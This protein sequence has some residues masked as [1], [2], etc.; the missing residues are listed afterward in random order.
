[1]PEA[2]T[3]DKKKL[4]LLVGLR[5]VLIL[6]CVI[7]VLLQAGEWHISSLSQY[8]TAWIFLQWML[9]INSLY[10][11]FIPFG[12]NFFRGFIAFQLLVDFLAETILIYLT[13][14]VFSVF[15]SLYFVSIILAGVLI[16]PNNSL[17]CASVATIGISGNAFVYFLA[18][19]QDMELPFL[20]RENIY[21]FLVAID[22][23]F[24]K[25]YL[26]A[27]GVSFYLVAFLSSRL[28]TTISRERILQK[29]ILQNLQDGV[30]V[31]DDREHTIFLNDSCRNILGLEVYDGW[32]GELI[33]RLLDIDRHRE[34]LK[35]IKLKCPCIFDTQV[36][37]ERKLVPVQVTVSNI[38]R[39]GKVRAIIL[40]LRDMTY[41][42]RMEEAIQRAN[43]FSAISEIAAM[44]AHEIR[45]P[46]TSIRGAVQ[47]LQN[48]VPPEDPRYVLMN[49]TIRESDRINGI[50]T[51]FLEFS[52]IRRPVFQ[53]CNVTELLQETLLLLGKREEAANAR[54]DREIE[55]NLIIKADAEQLKQIFYNLG[56]NAIESSS[57]SVALRVTAQRKNRARFAP[58]SLEECPGVEISFHDQGKG[59]SDE[60][61]QR[62]FTPFFTTKSQGTGMGL[63]FVNKMLEFHRGRYHIESAV[64]K[65]TS[66]YLWFPED[67]EE[68]FKA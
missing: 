20:P 34:I 68:T 36:P 40:I 42:K 25:A 6:C 28:S 49:I 55:E 59:I 13:G 66:F 14:G 48:I 24:C 43:Q 61:M 30:L 21:T 39:S 19:I 26:F 37:L 9:A 8:H 31:I 56:I 46:I 17:V 11:L 64:G 4:Y 12:D 62:I 47:E 27:Q 53:K 54:I 52:R 65:G 18:A 63:A 50:I 44:I 33:A 10:L 45:N 2:R 29:E 41:Q 58:M 35:A 67:P 23:P 5:Y 3:K 51:E 38:S 15:T 1:M 57:G 7:A 60:D 32:E 22:L 16:S